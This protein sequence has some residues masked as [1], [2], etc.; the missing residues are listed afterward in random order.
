MKNTVL[1]SA[2][3]SVTLTAVLTVVGEYLIPLP[4]TAPGGYPI[5]LNGSSSGDNHH[6]IYVTLNVQ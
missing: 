5:T 2:I 1:L 6:S 4:A 3:A